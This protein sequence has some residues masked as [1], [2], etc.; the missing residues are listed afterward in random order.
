MI[1]WHKCRTR[2]A[3]PNGV[4]VLLCTD[5]MGLQKPSLQSSRMAKNARLC[6]TGTALESTEPDMHVYFTERVLP[7]LEL[8]RDL[9]PKEAWCTSPS[10]TFVFISFS[11][12]TNMM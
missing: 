8:R 10:L 11:L 9:W 5:A 12:D 7:L 6:C 4:T 2:E 1:A 3:I